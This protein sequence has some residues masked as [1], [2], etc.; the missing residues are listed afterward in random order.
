MTRAHHNPSPIDPHD[1]PVRAPEIKPDQP[2]PLPPDHVPPQ[3][4]DPPAPADKP[5]TGVT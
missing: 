5:H 1:Q 3:P 2:V 4:V